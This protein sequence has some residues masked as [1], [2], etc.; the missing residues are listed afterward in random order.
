MVALRPETILAAICS[1]YSCPA[2]EWLVAEPVA[3]C[4]GFE[5]AWSSQQL[6]FQDQP[7]SRLLFAITF[8][9]E[10]ADEDDSASVTDG[11]Q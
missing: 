4:L 9:H 1:V 6:Q 3:S 10:S 2:H 5:S 8:R 11:S 7:Q